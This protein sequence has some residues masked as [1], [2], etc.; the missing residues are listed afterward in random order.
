MGAIIFL[1]ILS[2]YG[3]QIML[4]PES[5]VWPSKTGKETGMLFTGKVYPAVAV[6]AVD[7][8]TRFKKI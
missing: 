7:M 1:P 3:G 4:T 8:A 5:I 6:M 2:L